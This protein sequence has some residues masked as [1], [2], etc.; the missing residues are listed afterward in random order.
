MASGGA[1][2][3]GFDRQ[4]KGLG[5]K[6]EADQGLGAAAFSGHTPMMAQYHHL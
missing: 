3:V 4:I 5:R 6:T 1:A 2:D